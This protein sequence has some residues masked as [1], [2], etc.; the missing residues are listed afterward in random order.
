MRIQA[1]FTKK[2][3][4]QF[5]RTRQD[6]S[7]QKLYML[8]AVLALGILFGVVIYLTRRTM[9]LEQL[10]ARIVSFHTR[11]E[12]N[13]FIR[14]FAGFWGCDTI[15]F[16]L[17]LICGTSP[18]GTCAV[19]VLLFLK[20]SGIGALACL[21]TQNFQ[22]QTV[23]AYFLCVFPGKILLLLVLLMMGQNCI[24]MCQTVRTDQTQQGTENKRSLSLFAARSGI[25]YGI[26]LI[27]DLLNA[28]LPAVFNLPFSPPV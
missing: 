5:S 12:K 18:V 8:T 20:A 23:G 10:L 2:E 24:H 15:W 16:L 13:A 3:P 1:V 27:T 11:G 22:A 6:A 17:L 14:N 28:A 25:V 9:L 26:L 4:P 7:A 19:Y 21:Y